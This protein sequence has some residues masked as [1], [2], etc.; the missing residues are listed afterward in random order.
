MIRLHGRRVSVAY[1]QRARRRL[2][3]ILTAIAFAVAVLLI[4]PPTTSDIYAPCPW[5]AITGTHCPGCGSLRGLSGLLGGDVLALPRNNM[6]A[7][8]AVPFL[9]LSFWALV[10]QALFGYR[11]YRI[12]LTK[13]E[14]LLL[15]MAIIAYGILRNVFDVLAPIGI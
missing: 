2:A 5:R 14:T 8:L 9:G 3:L 12:M 6:L 4:V 15:A 1:R 11:P 7:A 13:T 10:S